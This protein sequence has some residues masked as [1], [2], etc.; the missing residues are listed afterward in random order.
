MSRIAKWKLEKTKVKVVF[1]LQFHATH[2]PQTGWDKLFISFIPADSGKATAKTT[3]ANVRNGTCKW[4]DPI[5]ET[6]R[7]LQDAKTKQYDEKMYKL[8]MA[9]G[10]SRSSL[11]G[12]AYINLADFADASKPSTVALPL[13][14]C[15]HGTV[16][17]VTVQLLTSKTG[18]RE[19]EQERELREKGLQLTSNQTIHEKPAQKLPA[20]VEM[21]NDQIDKVNSRV[22]FNSESRGLPSLGEEMEL[23][24]ENADS[25]IGI[26]GSSYTSENL[27]AEK[28]DTSSTHE[29]D[30][31]KSTTSADLC[32]PPFDQSPQPERGDQSDNQDLAQ[33]SSNWVHGWNPDYS[34]DNDLANDYEENNR[35][36]GSLK[37]AESSILELKQEIT[38]LQ[39]HADEFGA[40]TQK[41]SQQLA[42][43]IASGEK[44]AK[45]VSILKLECLK[46]KDDFEQLKHSG[47]DSHLTKKEVIEKDWESLYQDLQ[48][49]WS[50]GLLIMEDKVR[51]L[52]NKA[53]LRCHERDFR[54]LHSDFQAL[55][56]ILQDL[57]QGTTEVISVL[58]IVPG[59]RADV[60]EIEP[61]SIQKHEQSVPGEKLDGFGLDQYRSEDIPCCLRR[62][63]EFPEEHDTIDSIPVLKGKI[64]DLLRE[65]EESKAERENLTT[66]MDQMECYYEALVQ[67]LEESQ[68]QML[69]ELQSLR[70]EHA[71]CLY[72][73]SSCKAQMEVMHQDMN[74]QFLR[75]AEDRHNLESLNK[76]LER[77]AITSETA[78]KRARW[79]YSTAVDQLQKDLELL[80]YQVLSMFETNEN[81]ISQ[82]FAESS[83]PCFEEF[84]ETGQRAN[85]LLQEQYKTGVQRS[86]GMVHIS[87]KAEKELA[88]GQVPPFHNVLV[89]DEKSFSLHANIVGEV[90]RSSDALDSFSCPKTE[91]PLTKLS[92]EESYSAELFQCQNQNAELEKQ[93]LDGEI[94]FKDL[95]RSL[96]LQ[97]ELYRKAE[98]E[99]YEMHVANIHL[100]VYSKVLQEALHE[101]C[102]GITLMKER[103]D[104]LA[105]QL[106]KSTQSKELLMLRLQSALDDVKS[107]NECKLN[108]IAKCDD[109]GLQNNILE[110]KLESISNENFLLSEKIAECE[111]LMVEYGSYKNKYI[112]CSA[113]KTELA[114]L[115]KQETVEKYNLQNEVSTVHAELKT[116]KSK[117][118]KLGSERDNLEITINFLQDKLRSLMSTMLSYNEQLN[119]QTIQGKS[120]Q[121]ELENNDFINIILHLDELQKKTYETILQ[122]IQDKKDLEEERDIAQRSLNQKDSDILIMKQKFELDIQDM[123]TKLDLSNLNVENLQ[124]QFKDIA[125]KLEVSSGSEEKYAAENRDLSSKI[126][127]LEIQLEHV[128][129][130]N[131]NLVTKILKL[132][133]EKQ[134][135]EAEKDITRE[136]L[137]SK[138]SEILNM[139][140]KF[141][142]DVQDMVMKLHLSNAHVDKLQL[143]LEDTINKLNI[144]SQ[145]EEKYA[146]QNRGLV[147][148]IESLEI[149]LEHVSTENGNL[150]T[151]ILQVS[152]EKK[153]AEE[154]RDIAQ[155]SLSAKDSELMIMRKKLEF[156][157]QDMLSKLHLSNALAEELQLE[158]DT[159]R[160]LKV[161]SVAE[162]K[163]AEQ[164][165]GLVSKIEDL[166]IQLECVKSENRNLV[167]KIFQ[168]NQ[169][170]DAEEERDIVRGLLS[171]K[172][173]EILIIKQ[174]F[175]SDVQ[176][177]VS[178]LDM[179]NA[180]V[181][182]LQLQLEHIANK[183]NINSGAEEKY[184]EQSRELLSK[185]ADLEIQLE[186]VAS[187]NRNLARKILVF[188][189]TA[190]SEI[191][192]MRQKF[193]AD[194]QDMVTK[195]GLSDAHLEKLQLAL[196][197]IS[198]KL[199]VSSIADEKFAEQNNELLS[200]FAMMEVE[201]QQV[202]ADY[203]SIVQRA[204]VL[205]S[206]NEELERTKLII[207]ELKQENQTLIMSLQSSNEDCVKLG[208]E[209]STVKESLRSVQD[210]LHVERG[211]RAELEAT[212][213]DLTSQLKE[214]HDQLFSFNEQKAE[215]IQ[216]KQLVSDLELEK[217][218]VCH[219]L[220]TSEEFASSL[221]LQVI[222]L[223]NHLTEMHECLLAA[224]LKSIFTRNQ[225]QTRMEEL[226]QQVLSL[227]ACHEELFMK[228][229]DV[230]AALNKHVAS[231]AQCVEE[232]ARLL[233]T[234]NS[235]KSELEDSA[236]EKR[237]L[238]DENRAL[239]IELEKCKTEAAIAKISDIEDIHWYKIEVEQ[240]KCMLV[241]SEEE[242]DNLTA[243]RYELE[244]AIIALRAKLDEQH[245]QISLLEEYG[246]EVTMLR[247]KC[248]ELAHKLSEQILRA[249]EFKNLS[250]HLKELKDQ[251]DTESLQAREKRETEASSIAAQESL[252]IAFIREQ[253]ETKLQELKSQLYI[254]KK[255]G[256]EMLLKLQDALDEVETRKK[257]EVFHIKRNE[258]LSLKILEL[259][260]E[261][262]IVISDKREKVKAY[263]EMKAEL[264]C[265]LISL[266]CCKEEKE[267]V[268]ASLQECNE[269]RTRIAVE[270]RLMKEQ[271]ENSVSCINAQ[272]G[273]F[274]LGTPRH[275]IT[276]Q[277]TEKF[278]Q[279]PPVAGILSYERDA[280]DMFPANE[281]TR[282]HHPKSSDKNSLFPCEQVEDSCT[283]P[284]DESNHSSEQMKLPTVQVQK[285]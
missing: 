213:M 72:T 258:E 94:L 269:E 271:M 81:L 75:S 95:R 215:L 275:M 134:D 104:A 85:A 133:Q 71:S 212:V 65:L 47:L 235:M 49:R 282:S 57:R 274:G 203:R 137:G 112:T 53:C 120:L 23:N 208:V 66:K 99:L 200:K 285:F 148:K 124:L 56:C 229:F 202:T 31:I 195:L 211:L 25:A 214:N 225:F 109:L 150:E 130:E 166:E 79:S 145:A 266:D 67:E 223:E 247:N 39:S 127:D 50:K 171:C 21:A 207:T 6:T 16:L 188:E 280:I 32:G 161:N 187:E 24:E 246:N 248:N 278:Q 259:E 173:S 168:L 237:T 250:I 189:S 60:K 263:D 239:L 54:F 226:A 224:D 61:I 164:N 98:F 160:Q 184:S 116:I 147:S 117:F 174:K 230:L 222:D 155:R 84:L 88:L 13:Q 91:H 265:S 232:N 64:S 204:L 110:A 268:E 165:R 170:K 76:E 138:E 74:E 26:D 10:S 43:E 234:V 142:S 4:A 113:E 238:K 78:L 256:E 12:E 125:N 126:A 277:V 58:G 252:R 8:V 143:E 196:E 103:M 70:N 111:K 260:T 37:V 139:K 220:F 193:E 151:K 29:M 90:Q 5:Y 68:K 209:L 83:Q 38:S 231:E 62:P 87:Q 2:I 33:R 182:N 178:K 240:L 279:E 191:F 219:R 257:S 236:F 154:G 253:C 1:R 262:K 243:S 270:L 194:V 163:Y 172:D 190:E 218:R 80:S 63:M 17:H 101:A 144:S 93:L 186:H 14:G 48:V 205:E 129:T 15:S 19:F 206:I 41:F 276:E 52:Q 254:S 28:H 136:S 284:S 96:H 141:G 114:N 162:E 40:E 97:E 3:K 140:K 132:S 44:L 158:L 115:L 51:E 131:K 86:Q 180:H 128:T 197:D 264:E 261:L 181:E 9:M 244:I 185:F 201:L 106:D 273:N 179:F 216:I 272:E 107:L 42:A 149:Q 82:A 156:E 7:L 11:L 89:E 135:A 18:F 35:L 176:D 119:G 30:N 27:Y 105:E 92:C 20:S 102:S 192:M 69:G 217:S 100:D 118:D 245:G 167:T 157:V 59:E 177:M 34:M 153:D 73:I 175:E 228:H 152:Q 249:E 241:N 36:R 233:T 121:Q 45:E 198:K 242:I 146:E 123:V 199:K 251:V 22:G 210:K 46:L 255:H 281:K 267:K 77:R 183:L 122:L 283:V 169:E 55:Q 108:C 221:Q 227:D 159:S